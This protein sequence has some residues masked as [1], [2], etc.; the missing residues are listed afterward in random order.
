MYP[1][2]KNSE[3]SPHKSGKKKPRGTKKKGQTPKVGKKRKKREKVWNP[4]PERINGKTNKN[5][6][7]SKRKAK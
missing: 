3:K 4:I 6:D 2:K 7:T 1:P 5:G